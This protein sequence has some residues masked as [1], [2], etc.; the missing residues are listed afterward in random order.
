MQLDLNFDWEFIPGFEQSYLEQKPREVNAIDLPHN[1]VS[2]PFNYMSDSSSQIV[3][4]Y[5]KTLIIE[6][7]NDN[8]LYLLR[9]EGV[10]NSFSLFVNSKKV[11]EYAL[12]Y[13]PVT[14]NISSF[15]REGENEIVVVV[16]GSEKI[17]TPPFG[18]TIDYYPFS[19]IYREV[20]LKVVPK[21]YLSSI[22]VD[23]RKDGAINVRPQIV[24]HQNNIVTLSYKLFD[25]E[26]IVIFEGEKIPPYLPNI[27]VWS[28]KSPI[29][30]KLEVSLA[31]TYGI[32]KEVVS[33]GFRDIEFTENGFYLN[34]QFMKLIGLNRH[35]TY[36]Y[37]GAAASKSLQV[38]DV[39]KLKELGLNYVR[40]SHYPQSPHFLDACD[41]YGLLV[42]NE[43]PGWQHIG[44][45]AW[46]AK[47][48][49]NIQEMITRD[50]NHPS[51]ISWSIRINESVDN[52]LLYQKGH[53]LAKSLDPYRPTTG[54]RNFSNSNPLEDIYSYND[55]SHT[56]PNDGLVKKQKVTKTKK[57]Y[58]VSENNG[59]M[60]PTKIYDS[61]FILE[62]HTKRHF[63][64]LDSTF[65]YS[66]IV[67]MSSWCM[68]DYYTHYEFGSGDHICYHG[69]LDI[70]RFPKPAA[71]VYQSN[72]SKT[73]VLY[74][75][76]RGDNGDLPQSIL[77][78]TMIISNATKIVVSKGDLEI[79]TLYPRTDLYPHLAHPP[80]I[81]D[82]FVGEN[83]I[84]PVEFKPRHQKRVRN[85]LNFAAINGFEKM[86]LSR[87]LSLGFLMLRYKLT[88][89]HLVELWSSNV[90]G[91][92]QK[93][94]G[95]TLKAYNAE[96][97]LV[98]ETDIGPTKETNYEISISKDTLI[99]EATYDTLIVNIMSKNNLGYR[100]HYDFNVVNIEVSGPL[101]L[102]CPPS[103]NLH[104]GALA[105]YIRSQ[106]NEGNGSIKLTIGEQSFHY[107]IKI[108]KKGA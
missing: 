50:Y 45:E 98:K 10:N 25:E 77:Y 17:N 2:P 19:G 51:V 68:H 103:V 31:S 8:S 53:E 15:I 83:F 26:N 1:M 71:L 104:G 108:L 27:K 29:L 56:G 21:I 3:G 62:N 65:K 75:L 39:L 49:V 107:D 69:V 64:I 23:G 95:Y 11:G 36:A 76:F 47:H 32:H 54:T 7:I 88:R 63:A 93:N 106:N 67:G 48:L 60:F 99:N 96:N 40:S 9:F 57:P 5:F 14:A 6:K 42:V 89:A 81:L 24:N 34:G 73:P 16:S 30:Y 84:S 91:W 92:G 22:F 38:D 33:F 85:L 100:N 87:I 61:P 94:E 101:L 18:F 58:I 82:K 90:A 12:P 41:K 59:H 70:Y 97:E 4:T 13:L 102:T 79:T 20:S 105:L 80:F 66:N 55:F 35:E 28:L 44:D 46:Q 74:P 43:V 86:P 78:P 72:L 37:I 52:D